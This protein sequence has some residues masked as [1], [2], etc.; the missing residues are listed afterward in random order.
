A[1]VMETPALVWIGRRS[2]GLYLWHWPL[3]QLLTTLPIA[4][5]V[6]LA[7][8]A[9]GVSYFAVER[10]CLRLKARFEPR[11]LRESRAAVRTAA[12]CPEREPPPSGAADPLQIP[13]A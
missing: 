10:P 7:F 13:R 6:A 3:L 8:A 9:A 12:P 1:K 11:G 4:A 5:R 2:Y